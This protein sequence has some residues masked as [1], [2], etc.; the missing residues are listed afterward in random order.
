M[1]NDV[2]YNMQLGLQTDVCVLDFS[3]AFDKVKLDIDA[4]LR[5]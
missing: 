5:S 3:K 2:V 4:W 1:V